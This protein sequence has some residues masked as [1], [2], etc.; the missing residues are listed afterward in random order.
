MG[1]FRPIWHVNYFWPIQNKW[2]KPTFNI[3]CNTW[4]KHTF[5]TAPLVLCLYDLVG[6]IWWTIQRCFLPLVDHQQCGCISCYGCVSIH[7]C[8]RGEALFFGLV[9]MFSHFPQFQLLKNMSNFRCFQ[10]NLQ[11]K[12]N[13]EENKT[14]KVGLSLTSNNLQ[15]LNYHHLQ[16]N[17]PTQNLTCLHFQ[18]ILNKLNLLYCIKKCKCWQWLSQN[19]F[20]T[21]SGLNDHIM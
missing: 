1:D 18:P 12:F 10:Y 21:F 7:L 13:N 9:S 5:V 2:V 3:L 20:S 11:H 17:S 6:M 14:T 15:Y 16:S 19:H 8:Q 4:N